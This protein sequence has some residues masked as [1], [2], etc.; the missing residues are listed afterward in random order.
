MHLR[1]FCREI[2]LPPEAVQIVEKMDGQISELQYVYVRNGF[3][4]DRQKIF[5][6]IIASP[7]YRQR[8]LYYYCRLALETFD[9]YKE[10]GIEEKV[11]F[12]TF[13]DVAIWCRACFRR[14]G[15]YGIQE[16]EW[17]WRHVEMTIFRF[18]RLQFEKT[19]SPWEF[20]SKD[21][22]RNIGEP[23]ISIHIPEGEP[24]DEK[25]CRESIALGQKFWGKDLPFV[26]HSWLLF[27]DL[28]NLLDENSNIIRFQEMFDIQSVDFEFREGEERIFGKVLEDPQMYPE[29]T[30]LQ[31]DARKW[32]IRRNR[33]GSGLGVLKT[34]YEE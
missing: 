9:R 14:Y 25:L 28:K 8:F 29:K 1:R 7:G 17:L 2:N 32:L 23:I 6:E 4:T 18:G 5:K 12:D 33:L 20:C 11:F 3:W 16:Y 31:R 22:K 15:E 24:L 27:P 13:S 34:E 10:E 19:L 21:K 30:R 26:C